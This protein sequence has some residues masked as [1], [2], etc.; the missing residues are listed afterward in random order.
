MR[1]PVPDTC[2]PRMVD[3]MKKCWS[4]DQFFRPQAKDLD[5]LFMDMSMQ[6]AEPL[7]RAELA[8][9]TRTEKPTGDMLYEV[10]PKHIADALKAGQKVEPEDHENVTVFFSEI[11]H[12]NDISDAMHPVKVCNMLDRL[13]IAFE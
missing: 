1:P 4:P 10:F 9:K 6:D 3:I 5:Q 11:I 12:F 8:F 13:Y 2:P 7:N